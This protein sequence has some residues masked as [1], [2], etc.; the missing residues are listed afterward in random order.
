MFHQIDAGSLREPLCYK[1]RFISHHLNVFIPFTNENPFWSHRKNVLRSTY[2]RWEYLS[3]FERV[4]FYLD[5]FLPFDLAG[6][7]DAFCHELIYWIRLK[8]NYNIRAKI[9]ID[10]CSLSIEWFSRINLIGG[11]FI[12]PLWLFYISLNIRVKVFWCPSTYICV[13]ICAR[14]M[15]YLLNIHIVWIFNIQLVSINLMLISIW[16]FGSSLPLF[17]RM[18]FS[19]F[20]LCYRTSPS[21]FD[22]G[23]FE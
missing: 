13:H 14:Y 23:D 15:V 18:L 5:C 22:L 9:N 12:Y 20:I 11:N 10:N 21:Y 17:P 8:A 2:N 16:H 6:V 1:H 7:L 19:S 3:F 4:Q